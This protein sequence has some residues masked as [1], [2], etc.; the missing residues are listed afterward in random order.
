MEKKVSIIIPAYNAA[1]FLSACLDSVLSQSM[2][3]LEIIIID[4][5]STDAT[6]VICGHYADMDPRVNVIRKI[7]AGVSAARNM[8]IKRSSGEYIWFVDADDTIEPE[9]CTQLYAIAKESRADAVIFDYRRVEG[10]L[11]AGVFQSVFSPDV[12]EGNYI[13]TGLLKRFIGFTNDGIHRW[14][15]HEPEGLYVENPALWRTFLRGDLIRDNELRFDPSLRVGEDT[16]FLSLCLSYAARAVVTHSV[17]YCQRLHGGSTI[18]RYERDPEAKLESKLALFTARQSLTNDIIV[19]HGISV[20]PYWQGTVIMSYMEL[21][22]LYARPV[23][24]T[25]FG[26]RYKR[27]LYYAKDLRV[28]ESIAEFPL[29]R[30]LS[31]RAVPFW[32]MKGRLHRVLFFCAAIL[33]RMNYQFQR[34]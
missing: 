27:F 31:V 19:R 21:C 30:R 4:D 8:G 6:P 1:E 28:A 29:P 9:A 33:G 15:R 22:F 26:A 18:S 13:F 14:L 20:A 32:L 5:G 7:N 2:R 25:G 10:A 12:Y 24:G 17:L 34:E 23:A 11:D 16:I 3:E